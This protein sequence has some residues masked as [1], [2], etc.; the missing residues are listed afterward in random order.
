[1]YPSTPSLILLGALLAVALT[2]TGGARA[3][4]LNAVPG[5]SFGD[6]RLGDPWPGGDA[7]GERGPLKVRACGGRVVEVWLDDLRTAPACVQ[8]DGRALA[9]KASLDEIRRRQGDCRDDPEVRI[10]GAFTTCANGGLRLG[11]GLGDFLQVRVGRPGFDLDAECADYT[12]D[13]RAAPLSIADRD[14]LFQRV[15]DLPGLAPFWHLD[16]PGRRPLRA[17]IASAVG[18][19]QGMDAP[20]PSLTLGGAAVAFETG[21]GVGAPHFEFVA[22]RS[23]AR[24]V[25]IDV[26]HRLEGVSGT[27]VFRRRHDQWMLH[28]VN[29]AER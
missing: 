28:A 11:Y 7:F 21:S 8:L 13:G 3:C 17:A 2:P 24:R 1:M 26:R 15:I 9:P 4:P 20:A 18:E 23:T 14:A 29:L 27:I 16:L 10:G 12:D 25:E 5:V 22:L 6:V 19:A